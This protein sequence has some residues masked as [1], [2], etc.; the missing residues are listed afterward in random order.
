MVGKDSIISW[1]GI[2]GK[3]IALAESTGNKR[4]CWVKLTAANK[5]VF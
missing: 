1:N 3:V 2:G 4:L 5:R